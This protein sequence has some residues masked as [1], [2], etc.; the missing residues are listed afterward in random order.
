MALPPEGHQGPPEPGPIRHAGEDAQVE[1]VRE[2][3]CT[4]GNGYLASR[5]AAPEASAD[6]SHYPG[7]YVAG[8]FNRLISRVHG[9]LRED[10]SLVNLPN[11]S[12]L[13]WRAD[14]GGWV[15]PD[16]PG[17][18]EF[19]QS[20][21][22]RA[23]VVHR[24]YRHV[25]GAGRATTV[26][27]RML[28]SMAA[29][30]LAAL[31]TMFIAENWSGS[32]QV[33]SGIDARVTN[34]QVAQYA[35]MAG[36]H[37]R[38]EGQ[39]RDG[40]GGVWLRMRT[41]QSRIEVGVAVR[42]EV[43]GATA[44]RR[45]TMAVLRP[46]ETYMVPVQE[47]QPVRVQKVAAI[48][49]SRDRA[50]T[51]PATAARQAV[52]RAGSFDDLVA[53]QVRAWRRLWERSHIELHTNGEAPL[54]ALN[55]HTAGR[56]LT[57]RR[58]PRRCCRRARTGRST[59]ATSSGTNCSSTG[60]S[61]CTFPRRAARCCCTGGGAWTPPAMP[62]QKPDVGGRCSRG[63]P[64]ATAGRR[65]RTRSTTRIPVSGCRTMRPGSATLDWPSATASGSTT[66][67]PPTWTS[68]APT[69]LN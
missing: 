18:S 8:V 10:E 67:P 58:R 11:W 49:S 48:Y 53:G 64:A 24:R 45:A 22:L 46:Q 41:S 20:L 68:C 6:G 4:V 44:H 57:E 60:F 1:R 43:I 7:T 37:L 28:V 65:R 15:V 5:G 36:R 69:A 59:G 19:R 27:S 31:E 40:R 33:C 50:I 16:G 12:V 52:A 54:L 32:L 2:T 30:H 39:G 35:P 47:G 23:G 25:D 14:R 62:L 9:H 34:R 29:P 55:L 66:R 26:V 63:S 13:R 17:T 56:H 3:L 38:F 21:D 42:T 61:P 51:E